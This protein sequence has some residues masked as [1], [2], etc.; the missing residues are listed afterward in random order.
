MSS[1][2]LGRALG[3]EWLRSYCS[4]GY[5]HDERSYKVLNMLSI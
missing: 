1:R 3:R 5:L 2:Y 4:P